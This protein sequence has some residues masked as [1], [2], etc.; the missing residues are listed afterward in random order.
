MNIL[1]FLRCLGGPRQI[2]LVVARRMWQQGCLRQGLCLPAGEGRGGCYELGF[3]S[4]FVADPWGCWSEL[5]APA[6]A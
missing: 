4:R 5:L 6:P 3:P 1:G 2:L